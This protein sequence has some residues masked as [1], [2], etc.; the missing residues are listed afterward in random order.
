MESPPTIRDVCASFLNIWST[1]AI[2]LLPGAVGQGRG[3]VMP[4][5]LAEHGKVKNPFPNVDSHSGVL[6]TA[7]AP[8]HPG[9]II[10]GGGNY[11][12]GQ[13]RE[14]GIL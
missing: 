7:P 3:A 2:P 12:R 6:P 10:E 11:A 4:G 9:R 14:I 5:I 13:Q 1:R 8:R